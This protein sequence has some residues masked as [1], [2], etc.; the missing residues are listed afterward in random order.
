MSQVQT[1]EQL[2]E[3]LRASRTQWETLLQDVGEERLTEPGVAGDWAVKDLL[4]H[5]TAYHRVWGAH[6]RAAVTGVP[7]TLHDLYDL[8][9]FPPDAASWTLEQQNAAIRAHYAPL[10]LPEVLA[11]WREAT[12]LLTISVAALSD[13][14]VTTA[15]R[16]PWTRGMPLTEAIAG[17][18]YGHAREHAEQVRAWLER[19]PRTQYP[20]PSV[21]NAEE[22]LTPNA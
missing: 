8:D 15:D 12:D 2:L 6:A 10:S 4:G 11:G 7:P 3:T 13:E 5:L 9:E 19:V 21:A 18:T 1:K 17:D 16:F 20:V 14:D 22:R